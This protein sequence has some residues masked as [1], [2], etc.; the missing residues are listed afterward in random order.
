[1]Q[2][3]AHKTKGLARP[4]NPQDLIL[5][6]EGLQCSNCLVLI[7]DNRNNAKTYHCTVPAMKIQSFLSFCR[8]IGTVETH[9][10]IYNSTDYL[11]RI[12]IPRGNAGSELCQQGA[13]TIKEV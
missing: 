13:L 1:M 10:Q 12:F 4:C 9:Y 5:V 8:K 3:N 2:Y 7:Q 11:V 6:S